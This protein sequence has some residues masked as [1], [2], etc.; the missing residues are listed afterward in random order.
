MSHAIRSAKR[1]TCYHCGE[2][3]SGPLVFLA[4]KK[5]CCEGCRLVYEIINK[6]DL[7]NYYSLNKTPGISQKHSSAPAR[8]AFLDD[9]QVLDKL[10]RFR[11]GKLWHVVLYLPQMHC[12]SCI[13]LLENLHRIDPGVFRSEVNFLKKELTIAFDSGRT[14]LS[15]IAETLTTIG[16]EPHISLHDMSTEKVSTYSRARIFRIG[17]AGFCFANIMML[18]FPEYFSLGKIEEPGLR[19]AF[20]WINLGLSL[21]VFFYCA[22]EFFTSAWK[23][24]RQKFLNIDAPI[25]LALLITFSRSLYEIISGSG[26]GYLDSMSGIVFFMLVGRFFQDKTYNTLT[27]NRDYTSY[28]PLG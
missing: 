1:A 26:A 7:C 4:D 17:I 2:E 27:F 3:C 5:F 6:V 19:T 21:P 20:A 13:W 16:Y 22:S 24:L 14:T 10:I 8:F 23:G 11:E 12:S 25:A 28:F 15:S 18:S 9:E